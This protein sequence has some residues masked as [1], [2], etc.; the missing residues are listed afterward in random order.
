MAPA[1]FVFSKADDDFFDF[2]LYIICED[3]S[4]ADQIAELDMAEEKFERFF[5]VSREKPEEVT[6]NGQGMGGPGVGMNKVA[7]EMAATGSAVKACEEIKRV[8]PMDLKQLGL[9]IDDNGDSKL[10]PPF[11]NN[12]QA[13]SDKLG[14]K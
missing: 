2:H 1:Q 14:S 12:G 8:V 11:G 9:P 6:A 10:M 4:I 13:D 3:G 5:K 7:D